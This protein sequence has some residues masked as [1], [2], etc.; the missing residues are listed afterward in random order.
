MVSFADGPFWRRFNASSQSLEDVT[1]RC[2]APGCTGRM[3]CVLRPSNERIQISRG[4]IFKRAEYA[5][6]TRLRPTY[7]FCPLC[8]HKISQLY[9]Q[10]MIEKGASHE[11]VNQNTQ[12]LS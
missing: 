10:V 7:W 9:V 12:S 11:R 2:V 8:G 4:S 1:I 3:K 6:V 5:Q